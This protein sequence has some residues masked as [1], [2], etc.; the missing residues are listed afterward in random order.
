MGQVSIATGTP[1][2]TEVPEPYGVPVRL[3]VATLQVPPR[4][5]P[6]AHVL[7]GKVAA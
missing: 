1:T 4:T 6:V 2:E 5:L 3:A 7:K